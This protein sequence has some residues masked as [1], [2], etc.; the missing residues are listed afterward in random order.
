MK[1]KYLL[2]VCLLTLA[3]QRLGVDA[4][5]KSA[6]FF[7]YNIQLLVAQTLISQSTLKEIISQID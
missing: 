2:H 1:E 3:I 7:L 6:I 5:G 4:Q